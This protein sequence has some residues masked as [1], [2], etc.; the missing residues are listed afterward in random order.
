MSAN[1]GRHFKQAGDPLGASRPQPQPQP[2]PRPAQPHH[3]SPSETAQFMAAAGVDTTRAQAPSSSAASTAASRPQAPSGAVHRVP[4][5]P[6]VTQSGQTAWSQ[7]PQGQ[8]SAA[9]QAQAPW[10]QGEQSRTPQPAAPQPAAPQPAVLQP[11]GVQSQAPQPQVSQPQGVRPPMS[12]RPG[13]TAQTH[14][15]NGVRPVQPGAVPPRQQPASGA[16]AARH[17]QASR[18]NGVDRYHDGP[19]D[20]GAPKKRRGSNIVSNLLIVVGVA[21]LLV[22]GGLFLNA[23][24]GYKE[25]SAHYDAIEQAAVTDRA[26]DGI[27]VIDW[28]ALAKESDQIVGWIYVPGTRINYPVAK[29]R[30]NEQFLRHLPNGQYNANGT[31]F[32]DMD[33]TAPGVVD[34]QTTLYGHHMNDGSMF[35]IIDAT[36]NQAEF[37]K[38]DKVYYL[39][40]ETTYVFKPMFTAQVQDNYLDVRRTN[41]DSQEDFEAYLQDM[42]SQALAQA[43]DAK[44]RIKDSEHVITLVTCAGEIIP[45]TTRATMVCSLEDTMP[46]KR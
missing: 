9:P 8:N 10:P 24:K 33:G 46:T 27:P 34:Q 29:G 21:L 28:D 43:P 17:P 36:R 26:G 45:R 39:T 23:Q 35:Q 12:N 18:T 30:D 1:S 44:D 38:I 4:Q 2:Q 7:H 16:Y 6:S 31:I 22:A 25:A 37:D 14:A 20:G 5:V 41:F 19:A 11:Q 32:M 42:L 15:L 40:P 3:V 13:D